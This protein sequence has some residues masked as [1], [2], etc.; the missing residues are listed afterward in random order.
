MQE[1][2]KRGSN[3]SSAIGWLIFI[4]VIAGGPLLNLLRRAFG[5]VVSLPNNLL[6]L[7]IGGLVALSILASVVRAIG[8]S[9]R[10]RGD[11]RLPTDAIPPAR[12]PNTAMPPFGGPARPELPGA[13]LTPRSFVMPASSREPKLPQAPRF[14][15]IVSPTIM[16]V[17][18]V[19]VLLLAGAALFVFGVELP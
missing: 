14:E 6:P 18:V 12:L 15:P 17:G 3:W 13:P 8:S 19:G 7:L 1:R 9:S 10:A 11:A 4:L 5:G 2:R 16:L